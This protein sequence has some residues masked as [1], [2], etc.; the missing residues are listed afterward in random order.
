MSRA[1]FVA[2]LVLAAAPARAGGIVL[3]SYTG[4]RPA[5]ADR[6]LSPIL[7]ELAAR[8]FSTGDTLARTYES[9]VSRTALTPSGLPSDF[10]AQVDRGQRAWVSGKFD[11]AIKILTPLV[12]LAHANTGAFARDQS[13]REP[14]RKA[15]IEL[16]L[17]HQRTGDPTATRATFAE[18]LRAFPDTQLSGATYGPEAAEL[19]EQVHRETLTSGRGKL[20]VTVADDR[21]VVFVDET[22]LAV[23]ATTT[24]LAPG[25]YRVVTL[26]EQRPSRSHRVVIRKGED[27]TVAIDAVLDRVVHTTGWTGF[28]FASEPER[29]SHESAF[30]AAFARSV[31]ATAVAVIGIDQVRGRGAI[32]GSLVSLQTGREIRRASI[33]LE[34]D[35]STERLK[36]LARFL[37]GD[38]PAA[39]LEV[40]LPVAGAKTAPPAGGDDGDSEPPHDDGQTR[41]GRWGGWKWITGGSAV[42]ALG[43]G[44]VLVA[45][46]GRCSMTPMPGRLCDNVYNTMTPGLVVLGTGVAVAAV[47]VY[48]F[49]SGGGGNHPSHTAYLAPTSGGAFAGFAT[50]W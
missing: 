41:G 9:Q 26:L 27:T 13:L 33:A 5:D 1:A 11:D 38:E 42:T 21:Q 46:D 47:S 10:A 44:G 14:L 30:G 6:L 29:D 32:V 2:V 39:G 24:E 19:F 20:A 25:E 45:I 28:S 22:F 17:S 16:A 12:D 37:A 18:I 31:G 43:V 36:A 35:P 34:P 15:M 7:D 50:T 4:D 8:G 49:A 23:G 48:L 40:S 3:Q